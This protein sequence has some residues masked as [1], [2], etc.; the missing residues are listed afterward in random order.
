MGIY[1]LDRIFNPGVIAVIGASEKAG[2]VGSTLMLNLI[3]S[4]FD[5]ELFP[6]NPRHKTIHGLKSIPSILKAEHGIDLAVIAT[7][8]ATVPDIVKECVQK[9][10]KG[11]VIVSAGGK[12]A[13]TKG[14]EIE[15]QIGRYAREGGLRVVGPNCLGIV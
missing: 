9:G 7:P 8:I 14:Q 15:A 10:V 13:G 1:N 12:E 5:G 6:V 3:Q 2:S 4:G 11:A